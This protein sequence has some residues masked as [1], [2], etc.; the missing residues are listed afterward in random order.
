MIRPN[1]TVEVV[2]NLPPE[3]ER[4]RERVRGDVISRLAAS[5]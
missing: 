4:L 1:A 2:P 5:A 3:L